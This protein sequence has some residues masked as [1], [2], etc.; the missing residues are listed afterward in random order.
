LEHRVLHQAC[1][2]WPVRIGNLDHL[3]EHKCASV[4]PST[5]IP[6]SV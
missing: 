6:E 3:G 1:A 2:F 5:W 4:K